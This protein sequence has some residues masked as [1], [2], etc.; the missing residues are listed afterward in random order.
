[1]ETTFPL[2]PPSSLDSYRE[3]CVCSLSG[4]LIDG[5]LKLL[6][7]LSLSIAQSSHDR[8][9]PRDLSYR[10]LRNGV[11]SRPRIGTH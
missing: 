2:K 8:T 10:E 6:V 5:L 1:M 9:L 4:K 3:R 7:L 11:A